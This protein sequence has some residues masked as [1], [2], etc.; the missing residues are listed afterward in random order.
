MP[1]LIF[2]QKK[3][4]ITIKTNKFKNLFDFKRE[5]LQIESNILESIVMK[6]THTTFCECLK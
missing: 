4:S 2:P 3:D 6:T 5:N 1:I